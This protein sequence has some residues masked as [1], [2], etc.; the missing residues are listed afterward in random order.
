MNKKYYF[1]KKRILLAILFFLIENAVSVWFILEPEKFIGNVFMTNEHIQIIG[2]LA[3]TY[4][5][6]MIL[7]LF[8]L[9]FRKNEALIISNKYLIDN[10]KF[11]SVGKIYF[12][13]IQEVKKFGKYNIE[14]I[15]KD[16]IFKIYKLNIFQKI[17]YLSNNWY[18]KRKSI[19]ITGQLMLDCNRDELKKNILKAMK[20]KNF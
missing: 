9:L 6:I 14:I 17:A 3:F 19:L 8:I 1:N 7:S 12:S 2:F 18:F 11:E 5:L 15:L 10:S 16:S 13:D 20:R 4:S